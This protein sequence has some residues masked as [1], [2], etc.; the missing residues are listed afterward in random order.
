[1]RDVLRCGMQA[2]LALSSVKFYTRA[3]SD[4]EV[5]EMYRGGQPL[6]ELASGSGMPLRDF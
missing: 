3:L 2:G 5:E 6:F 1:M 4:K